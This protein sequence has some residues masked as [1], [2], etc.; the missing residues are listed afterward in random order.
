MK[1]SFQ[2]S[3]F[4]SAFQ[5]AAAVTSPRSPKDVLANVKID[6]TGDKATLMATD[7]E[8]GIRNVEIARALGMQ[9]R[10]TARWQQL[11]HA[12]VDAHAT[13]ALRAQ[14]ISAITKCFRLA[15]QVAMLGVG[16]MLVVDGHMSAG[17]MMTGTLIL[18]RALSPVENAIV[19]WKACADARAAWHRLS[20]AAAHAPP[21]VDTGTL[22]LPAPSGA[23]AADRLSFTI[24][25]RAIL[26]G[27]SFTL[28]AGESLGIVGA[29]GAGK[30]TLARLLTGVWR[31]QH[32]SVRLDG[33]EVA[34]WAREQLGNYIGYLPQDVQL[35]AGT[36]AQNIARLNPVGGPDG[37]E[38]VIQA[39]KRAG[40][41]ELI[42][43][44]PN[45]Y[46]TELGAH[47]AQLSGGQRQRI[48]LARALYG[49]PRL[50]VLDEPNASMDADGE[51]A[52]AHTLR[53]LS[54]DGVSVIVI[55]HHT[56]LIG[57]LDKL[58]V[59]KD[60]QVELFGPRA[61]VLANLTQTHQ[62]QRTPRSAQVTHLAATGRS[63]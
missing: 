20:A 44:M 62:A 43:A 21:A 4:Q 19:S 26:K 28:R 27:V 35:F 15:L 17:I 32:G 55:T 45:G 11:N 52:L 13:S 59:L 3:S 22:Q 34:Q 47:G 14:K 38:Q 41:H 6:A 24:G 46:D 40:V 58:L 9:A 25:A 23:L 61:D 60:G 49:N 42:Q 51:Q 50:L 5:I 57:Q 2:R 18:A 7:L 56:A 12:V 8:A 37:S 16:A 1:I 29:S 31:A 33:F 48:A 63:S 54:E 30:T 10:L 39:A 53:A 36:V